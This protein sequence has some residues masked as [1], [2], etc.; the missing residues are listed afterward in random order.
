MVDQAGSCHVPHVPPPW[1][2]SRMFNHPYCT[3]NLSTGPRFPCSSLSTNDH[4]WWWKTFLLMACLPV[5][6]RCNTIQFFHMI[7]AIPL[8]FFVIIA[9]CHIAIIYTFLLQFWAWQMM[10]QCNLHILTLLVIYHGQPHTEYIYSDIV[11]HHKYTKT[12][13]YNERR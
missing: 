10:Y 5:S 11:P 2:K 7:N 3:V 9:P 6:F 13:K 12:G 8:A 1:S 4:Y